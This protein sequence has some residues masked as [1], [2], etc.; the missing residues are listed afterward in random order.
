MYLLRISFL[1]V[2]NLR[3][4][5]VS[6]NLFEAFLCQICFDFFLNDWIWNVKLSWAGWPLWWVVLKL[7]CSILL[8]IMQLASATI[9]TIIHYRANHTC[10]PLL[11]STKRSFPPKFSTFNFPV[12]NEAGFGYSSFLLQQAIW[13]IPVEL[14]THGNWDINN[15][16]SWSITL[17]WLTNICPQLQVLIA[18]SIVIA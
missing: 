1:F 5:R 2:L 10:S 4:T 14:E 8:I 15:N 18:V 17:V 16:W 6:L 11:V 3:T 7:C 12:L 13:F 9:H